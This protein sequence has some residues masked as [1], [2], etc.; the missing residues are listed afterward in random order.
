MASPV[1]T[2]ARSRGDERRQA[3]FTLY[4]LLVVTAMIGLILVVTLPNLHRARVRAELLD[5]VKTVRQALMVARVNAIKWSRRT[6][7]S[8]SPGAVAQPS[9][10]IS[11]WVDD[12]GDDTLNAGDQEIGRWFTGVRALIGPDDSAPQWSLRP[13]PGGRRGVVFLPDGSAITHANDV[14]IGFGSVVLSD[15]KGN[16]I[17]LVIAASAGTVREQMWN[18]EL[19]DWADELRFWRY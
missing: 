14:G 6:V 9:Q 19:G 11:A 2:T 15:L 10:V 1:H 17:R 3:G 16:R 4:E 12:L 8:L 5:D 7:V 18:H 13:L